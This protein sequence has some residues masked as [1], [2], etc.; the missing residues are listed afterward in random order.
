MSAVIQS[1]NYTL[2]IDTGFDY[3]SFRLDDTTKGILDN[4]TY[5]LG[6][7]TQFA[8]ITDN[9]T[10]IVY[11]RGRRKPDDQIGAGTLS[12]TMRD[13]TGIL[14]PYDSTS[15]YYD[16]DNNEPGLAPMRAMRLKRG[17]TSLFTGT[18]ISYQYIFAKAGPNTVIVQC[19]DDFYKL[20]QTN[21]QEWNVTS[22]T[23]SQRL[24]S[25]L[26]LPEVDY[27]G[28]T[29]IGTG[30]V[31]LGHD[32]PYTVPAGTN[33][34]GYINQI[35]QAEQGRIFIAADGTLTFQPRIG[36]TLSA[37]IIYFNDDGTNTKYDGLEIEFD[38]ENVV[39]YAYIKALDGD[40]AIAQ[41][42]TS[43]ATYFIQAKQITNSLLHEQTQIDDLA[44]YLLEPYPAPRY[45]AVT[46][47]F[48]QITTGQRDTVAT[49][50]IGDTISIEKEIPGLGS[51][52][53]QELAIEGIQATINFD[54]GHE[55]TFFTSPTIIVFE[56]ILDDPIYGVLDADN[57]LG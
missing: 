30:T 43:Q 12:F 35:N 13:T 1:G 46:V 49:V 14:G 33:T 4:T 37:P 51:P 45:T 36:A 42:L 50:E 19:A 10:Q 44:T 9:V 27:T 52:L 40:D 7:T 15:P 8:D 5:L 18:I 2:E 24:T 23:S 39:N 55:I 29:N 21:L 28:T 34:L 56:L 20:A 3:A 47:K 31:N 26:A 53:A 38:A 25:L 32:S 57:V 11:R 6:P 16:P 54:R 41:D 48:A 22:E 17:T